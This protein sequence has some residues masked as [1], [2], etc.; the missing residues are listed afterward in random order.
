MDSVRSKY[1]I[2]SNNCWGGELY[3]YINS[4]YY[5]PFIGLYINIPCYMELLKQFD[6]LMKGPLEFCSESQYCTE[7]VNYPLG[8]LGQ[9]V[10]LHFV[11]Y[12]SVEEAREKWYRRCDRMFRE[13]SNENYF[14]KICDRDFCSASHLKEFHALIPQNKV[15]FGVRESGFS[16]H[17]VIPNPG[18]GYVVDGRRLFERS[19]SYMDVW[20]WLHKLPQ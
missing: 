7:I 3:R 12:R 10:E 1:A 6:V 11:H 15:S 2:I 5:S 16:M 19:K 8:R 17:K 20:K 4:E 18:F 9:K 14:Y 13:V